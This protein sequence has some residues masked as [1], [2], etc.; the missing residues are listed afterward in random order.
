MIS[1]WLLYVCSD[2]VWSNRVI[3]VGDMGSPRGI[4]CIV[5]IYKDGEL[6]EVISDLK[7]MFGDEKIETSVITGS[8]FGMVCMNK[9]DVM[10][11]GITE[12]LKR[13]YNMTEE[14]IRN[15]LFM[16]SRKHD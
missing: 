4:F 1:V 8:L 10:K 14:D 2:E 11:I 15:A 7:G 5:P 6:E 13:D 12:L 9:L 16:Q 3:L